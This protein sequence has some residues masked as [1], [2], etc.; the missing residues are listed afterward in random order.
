MHASYRYGKGI[1]I[2]FTSKGKAFRPESIKMLLSFATAVAADFVNY[3]MRMRPF[4]A[5]ARG[6]EPSD[7]LRAL[8]WLKVPGSEDAA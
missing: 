5:P 7:F 1:L 8:H 3:G 2:A 6:R 4:L